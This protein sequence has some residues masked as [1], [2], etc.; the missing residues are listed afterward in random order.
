MR[1]RSAA[2]GGTDVARRGASPDAPAARPVRRRNRPPARFRRIDSGTPDPCVEVPDATRRSSRKAVK[3][4]PF[5]DPD[6]SAPM[7]RPSKKLKLPARGTSR[8]RDASPSRVASGA[9]TSR[10]CRE[11]LGGPLAR[12]EDLLARIPWAVVWRRR[13]ASGGAYVPYGG[14]AAWTAWTTE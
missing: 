13:G 3:A 7:R 2:R 1:T 6:A 11:I 10:R 12:V 8:A 4:V 9:A 5:R 14:S